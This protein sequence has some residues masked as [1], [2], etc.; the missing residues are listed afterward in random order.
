MALKRGGHGSFSTLAI[1]S[2]IAMMRRNVVLGALCVP[3]H[4]ALEELTLE[5]RRRIL[6][7][8]LEGAEGSSKLPEEALDL[9]NVDDLEDT[10][11]YAPTIRDNSICSS[12]HGPYC[13][14]LGTSSP[15]VVAD[16]ARFHDVRFSLF[17]EEAM[18]EIAPLEVEIPGNG[19]LKD[20]DLVQGGVP[21]DMLR[22][23][24]AKQAS[25]QAAEAS[26]QAAKMKQGPKV[27]CGG[28]EAAT[29]AQCGNS[30]G[31]CNGDCKWTNE[32]TC[33]PKSA[34]ETSAVNIQE[35]MTAPET[36]AETVPNNEPE[37]SAV[38]IQEGMI[39]PETIP[40]T[41][42]EIAETKQVNCGA[43]TAATCEQCPQG[44]GEGWCHGDCKW[45]T[46]ETCVPKDSP[47]PSAISCG[48]HTA[49]TCA[50]C[51]TD[52]SYCNG[53]CKWH[54]GKCVFKGSP[55]KPGVTCGGHAAPTCAQCGNT[56]GSCN[57]DCTWT[58]EGTCVHKHVHK[59]DYTSRT[60]DD[61]T[62]TT[63]LAVTSPSNPLEV[64]C[65]GHSA[66]TCAQ[67][68]QG[69]GKFWCHGDCAWTDEGTCVPKDDTTR[70]T[71][72]D[73]TSTTTRQVEVALFP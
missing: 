63:T 68:P 65:G 53:D 27:S 37:T 50:Q 11:H 57:G 60:K 2:C 32:D 9:G 38:D 47:E 41:A 59:R 29:C 1:A 6:Q 18:G 49:A 44:K 42:P 52:K 20:V 12:S 22:A 55:E 7:P 35:G 21:T 43:H 54:N 45:T 73:T 51:G 23:H 25:Q 48:R 66:A 36:T 40:E 10:L 19:Q 62:I 24:L 34:P 26:R 15:P 31:L 4:T 8:A 56:K 61:T 13:A 69:H 14:I 28:H 70:T 33:V 3:Q 72:D 71:K 46:E 67:C 30:K 17:V 39:A 64:S 16:G 5:I 58:D